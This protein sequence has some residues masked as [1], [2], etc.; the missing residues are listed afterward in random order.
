M[1]PEGLIM[2]RFGPTHIHGFAAPP[3]NPAPAGS[4]PTSSCCVLS[5]YSTLVH[6]SEHISATARYK[7]KNVLFG[8]HKFR[9]VKQ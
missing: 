3:S 2:V 8:T 9:G 5:S 1:L 4:V 7:C 6:I